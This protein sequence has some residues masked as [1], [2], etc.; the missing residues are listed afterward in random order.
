MY[1]EQDESEAVVLGARLLVKAKQL[2]KLFIINEHF[3]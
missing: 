3:H 1:P 2:T